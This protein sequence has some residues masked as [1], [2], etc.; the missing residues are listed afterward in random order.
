MTTTTPLTGAKTP[1]SAAVSADHPQRDARRWLLLVFVALA[2]LMIAL[3]ATI[4]N[5]ALPS[6]QA[7]LGFSDGDRQ[8]VITAYALAF[9]GLMLLGGRIADYIGRTRAFVIALTGFASASAVGALAPDLTLLAVA[10]AAQGAFG[11]LLAPTVLSLLAVTFTE[12]RERGKAFAIFGAIAGG[13]GAA[14]LVLGGL[15][16]QSVGWRACLSVNVPIALVAGIGAWWLRGT[17][18]PGTGGRLDLPGALLAGA[19]LVAVVSGCTQAAARGWTSAPVM[20]LWG[21]GAALLALFGLWEARA[22]HPL[23]PLRIVVDRNRVG[24]CLSAAFAVAGMLGL[25][26]FLTYYLQVVL[27]YSPVTAGLAF[28]PLSGAVLV[29]SQLVAGRLLPRVAPRLLIVPGLLVAAVA[30][31]LFAQLTPTSGYLTSVLVP[32]ILLGLGMGCVFTP[33]ISTATSH[34]A[35]RDAG[36]VAAVVNSAQQIGGALGVA[37]LN[38]VATG[39]AAG[40]L[41]T[42]PGRSTEHTAALL[43]GYTTAAGWAAVLLVVGA[44]LAA[45]LISAPAP[46]GQ[47][48]ER[49]S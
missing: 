44:V 48:A 9:G 8:W 22:A 47:H 46:T 3:D 6:V 11:A 32:E 28:L 27:G 37:A 43:H 36:V 24:T 1:G 13:G 18:R 38:T 16:V 12:P 4:M 2:Q 25:F 39:A 14:G 29:S 45:A 42:H 35:P 26:L 49:R 34:V 15:L 10:R 21:A 33:A 19:G 20:A 5:I 31:V 7:A 17:S 30:M 23:L 41:V 40:Y